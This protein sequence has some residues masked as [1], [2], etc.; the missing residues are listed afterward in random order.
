MKSMIFFILV[1]VFLSFGQS[2]DSLIVKGQKATSRAHYMKSFIFNKA[3]KDI[4]IPEKGADKGMVKSEK[5][6][7]TTD[8]GM[9]K[10]EK[11]VDTITVKPDNYNYGLFS[12]TVKSE[13]G[14]NKSVITVKRHVTYKPDVTQRVNDLESSV[15]KLTT[16]C[17]NLQ[18]Q[19]DSHSDN[20][21]FFLKW[22]EIIS[23]LVSIVGVILGFK[24]SKKS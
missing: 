24:F 9:V 10:S 12:G 4:I 14:A 20:Q 19:S 17:T 6:V 16:I 2:L 13:K 5:G 3:D 15:E 11:S 23:G 21:E 7:D 8:K 18:K 22:I 1:T